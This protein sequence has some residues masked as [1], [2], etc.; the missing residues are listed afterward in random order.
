MTLAKLL[1]VIFFGM[2]SFNVLAQIKIKK[3]KFGFRSTC[4][5]DTS[6]KLKCWGGQAPVPDQYNNTFGTP[7]LID[8]FPAVADV[9]LAIGF[10]CA[11]S[12]SDEV[13]CWGYNTNGK[14]GQGA[15]C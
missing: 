1:L 12:V 3:N 4:I 10:T 15:N 14:L 13:K 11:L 9:E 7:I 2:N 8:V 5:I 6:N